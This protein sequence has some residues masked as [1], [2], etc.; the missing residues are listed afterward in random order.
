MFVLIVL[1]IERG[2]LYILSRP[3]LLFVSSRVVIV[4]AYSLFVVLLNSVVLV[5]SRASVASLGI[6]VLRP[7]KY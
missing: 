7:C 3:F 2:Y 1:T 4:F 6:F 5:S